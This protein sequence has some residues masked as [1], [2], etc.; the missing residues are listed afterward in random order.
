MVDLEGPQP[1]GSEWA[2]GGLGWEQRLWEKHNSSAD[3][4]TLR[5][6]RGRGEM[7]FAELGAAAISSTIADHTLQLCNV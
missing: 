2:D 1:A 5:P 3:A 6:H 7:A 4:E